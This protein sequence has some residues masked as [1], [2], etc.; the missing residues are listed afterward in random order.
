MP[1]LLFI[2]LSFYTLSVLAASPEEHIL[3]GEYGLA[4]E[5]LTDKYKSKKSTQNAFELGKALIASG[6][7]QNVEKGTKIIK[8]LATRDYKPAQLLLKK[9][10][11]LNQITL[12]G[13]SNPS[14]VNEK[15]SLAK[16]YKYDLKAS[17][18]EIKEVTSGRFQRVRA[19]V[20]IDK[21]N[22]DLLSIA[23]LVSPNGQYSSLFDIR[24]FLRTP[25]WSN[26][27]KESIDIMQKFKNVTLDIEGHYSKLKLVTNY[28]SIFLYENGNRKNVSIQEFKELVDSTIANADI[29]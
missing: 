3:K 19:E 24:F 4:I 18:S 13:Q 6:I 7:H 14:I 29:Y 28:P 22:G 23:K 15:Y 5:I 20:F 25:G 16:R 9:T 1:K 12:D 11:K 2:I 27:D 26:M 8:A 21:N 10:I 17:E